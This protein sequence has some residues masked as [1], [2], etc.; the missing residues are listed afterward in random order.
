M[1]IH[2]HIYTQIGTKSVIQYSQ[3]LLPSC[4][5]PHSR[6]P[7]SLASACPQSW[8]ISPD[9]GPLCAT[10]APVSSKIGMQRCGRD[11]SESLVVV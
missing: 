7:V 5:P 2:K 11:G 9:P 10:H 3:Q 1:Y 6:P 4:T 8:R